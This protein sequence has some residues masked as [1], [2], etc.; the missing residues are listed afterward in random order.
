MSNHADPEA[1]RRLV[2]WFAHKVMR[3]LRSLGAKTAQ[4]SDI[5]QELW[6]AWCIARDNFDPEQGVK[7]STYLMRGM[8]LHINRHVLNQFE[9]VHSEITALSLDAQTK[10]S[11]GDDAG[12]LGDI[13]ADTDAVD[14]VE[15]IAKSQHLD[16]VCSRLTP[17]ARSFVTMIANPPEEILEELRRLD[18]KAEHARSMDIT[19]SV[20][21]SLMASHVFGVMGATRTERTKI[22]KEIEKVTKRMNK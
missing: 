14:P 21:R 11:E 6:C 12:S 5:E 20:S 2:L 16:L 13:I 19:Y 8:K 15:H 17:R 3:R 4:F 9:K 7:F 1:S 18:A 10:G 22:F